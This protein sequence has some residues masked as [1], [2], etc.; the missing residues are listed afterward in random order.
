M[1]IGVIGI[2]RAKNISHLHAVDQ[3]G[4]VVFRCA[5]K[6]HDWA[7]S[8]RERVD[9][10]AVIAMEGWASAHYW[11]RLLKSHG[12]TVRLIPGQFVF[13]FPPHIYEI[14]RVEFLPLLTG[15]PLGCRPFF[16]SYGRLA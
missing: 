1:A 9:L 10:G 4:A 16:M 11:G 2:A 14:G 7:D 5:R 6:R 15:V 3:R 8:V 12:Y 13:N